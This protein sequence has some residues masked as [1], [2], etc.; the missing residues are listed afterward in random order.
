MADEPVLDS[1]EELLKP[2][3]KGFV[4]RSKAM[5]WDGKEDYHDWRQRKEDQEQRDREEK[6]RIERDLK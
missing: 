4:E 3:E 1:D 5:K 6:A 2:D